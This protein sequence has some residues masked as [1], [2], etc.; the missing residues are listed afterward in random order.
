[1]SCLKRR[2]RRCR[3]RRRS[4]IVITLLRV[5][6]GFRG[7][8]AVCWVD[9]GRGDIRYLL[10]RMFHCLLKDYRQDSGKNSADSCAVLCKSRW[11]FVALK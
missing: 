8:K 7:D 1:M 11:E 4:V 9:F 5:R 2:R 3:R 10:V 6:N